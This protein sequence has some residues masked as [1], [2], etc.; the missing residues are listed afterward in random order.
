MVVYVLNILNEEK[1]KINSSA[2]GSAC[3]PQTGFDTER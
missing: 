3:L 2:K 1:V